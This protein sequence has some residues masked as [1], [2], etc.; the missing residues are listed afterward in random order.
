MR[1]PNLA[2]IGWYYASGLY[3][4]ALVR[5]AKLTYLGRIRAALFCERIRNLPTNSVSIMLGGKSRVTEGWARRRAFDFRGRSSCAMLSLYAG[6]ASVL[7][8]CRA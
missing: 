6:L 8:E 7:C 4:P 2:G 1:V 3:D 5:L